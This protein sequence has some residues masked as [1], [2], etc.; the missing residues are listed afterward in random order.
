MIFALLAAVTACG[1]FGSP[2]DYR[3]RSTRSGTSQESQV[4]DQKIATDV[5]YQV[6]FNI[7]KPE[8]CLKISFVSAIREATLKDTVTRNVNTYYVVEK[9]VD[10]DRYKAEKKTIFYEV[11]RNFDARWNSS[12][13]IVVCTDVLDPLKKIDPGLYRVRFSS[14]RSPEYQYTI[15]IYSNVEPVTFGF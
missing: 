11:G 9:I 6:F 12:H 15:D 14:F 1:T 13:I 7:K 8:K 5:T 4:S 3:H 10:I 2:G